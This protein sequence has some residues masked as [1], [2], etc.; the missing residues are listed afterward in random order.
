M[1]YFR[2]ISKITMALSTLRD[3]FKLTEE[4]AISNLC[5]FMWRQRHMNG[6]LFSVILN[7]IANY[8]SNNEN[9]APKP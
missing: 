4:D 8:D 5:E 2:L 3:F 9:I 7:C 6:D 1:K